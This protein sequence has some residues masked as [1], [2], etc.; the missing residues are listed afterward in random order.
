MPIQ[1]MYPEDET[2]AEPIAEQPQAEPLT[3]ETLWQAYAEQAINSL[4]PNLRNGVDY[5]WGRAPDDPAGEPHILGTAE[6]ITIDEGKIREAA[7]KLAD[8]DPYS[9]YEPSQPLHE[10]TVKEPGA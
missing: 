1:G 9:F 7:Q 3:K 8:A 5:A 10:G 2:P 6:G 4:Y